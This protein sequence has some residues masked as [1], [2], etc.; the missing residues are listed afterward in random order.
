MKKT[1]FAVIS[2]IIVLVFVLSG[3]KYYAHYIEVSEEELDS[4][5]Q[6]FVELKLGNASRSYSVSVNAEVNRFDIDTGEH[7]LKKISKFQSSGQL[8]HDEDGYSL[9]QKVYSYEKTDNKYESSAELR[10]TQAEIWRN[11][12]IEYL[13][14]QYGVLQDYSEEYPKGKYSFHGIMSKPDLFDYYILD[15]YDLYVFTQMEDFKIYKADNKYKVTVTVSLDNCI[16]DEVQSELYI[17]LDSDGNIRSVKQVLTCDNS[18][19]VNGEKI[20]EKLSGEVVME[21]GN[22]KVNMPQ[23]T[24]EFIPYR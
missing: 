17:I 1:L 8:D 3:C 11:S 23:N 16:V 9:H 20:V 6:S 19:E 13:D 24:D 7:L 18:Y 15:E 21:Y 5:K 2:L 4:V 12:A 22:Y 10:E 14:V